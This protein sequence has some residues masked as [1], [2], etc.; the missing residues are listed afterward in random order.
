M[1]TPDPADPFAPPPGPPAAPA[2]PPAAGVPLAGAHAGPK[3]L[4]VAVLAGLGVALAAGL[5]DGFIVKAVDRE[6]S[7]LAIGIAA[8]VGATVG[9]LGGKHPALPPLGALLAVAGQ[10]FGKLFGLSL[11]A[12]ELTGE[13]VP[14]LFT[15]GFSFLLDMWRGTFDVFSAVFLLIG[16]A[17]GFSLTRTFGD[18]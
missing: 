13:S 11:I 16:A 9:K 4:P 5:L 8:A 3:N 6:F 17:V 15:D 2:S 18:S 14:A 10:V 7:W 1:T 12:H